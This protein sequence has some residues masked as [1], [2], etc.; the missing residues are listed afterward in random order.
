M[1]FQFLLNHANNLC[2]EEDTSMAIILEKWANFPFRCNFKHI[3]YPYF[4]CFQT[5]FFRL[6]V[7]DECRISEGISNGNYFYITKIFVCLDRQP[8]KK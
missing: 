5:N 1:H 6:Q 2:G 4:T 3:Q 8:I 7:L